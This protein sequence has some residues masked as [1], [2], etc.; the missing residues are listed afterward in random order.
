MGM[1]QGALLNAQLPS[2]TPHAPDIPTMELLAPERANEGVGAAL[3]P[4]RHTFTDA[5]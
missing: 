2:S 1:V 3:P 5:P 4:Q